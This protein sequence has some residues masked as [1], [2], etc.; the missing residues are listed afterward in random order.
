MAFQRKKPAVIGIK[1]PFPDFIEPALATSVNKVPAA[2]AGFTKSNLMAI[3]RSAVSSTAM[4]CGSC[5]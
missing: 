5:R 2:T 3:V 1:A 4:I